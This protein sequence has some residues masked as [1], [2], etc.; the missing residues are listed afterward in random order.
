M[1]LREFL[2]EA[3][4]EG[5]ALTRALDVLAA[6]DISTV[7]LLN[8]AWPEVSSLLRAGPRVLIADALEDKQE[9]PALK[10]P[11]LRKAASTRFTVAAEDGS[12]SVAAA[13][14]DALDVGQWRRGRRASLSRAA[15]RATV[16]ANVGGEDVSEP[17]WRNSGSNVGGED[18][19]EPSCS[20]SLDVQLDQF[21]DEQSHSQSHWSVGTSTM[22]ATPIEGKAMRAA[23]GGSGGASSGSAASGDEIVPQHR[24][25][26]ASH[27]QVE[28][29]EWRAFGYAKHT[30]PARALLAW[31]SSSATRTGSANRWPERDESTAGEPSVLD[32]LPVIAARDMRK[33]DL[34]VA[35]RLSASTATSASPSSASASASH[36]RL[37]SL[38]KAHPFLAVRNSAVLLAVAEL[39]ISTVILH[40]RAFVFSTAAPAPSHGASSSISSISSTATSTTTST[41]TTADASASSLQM[42]LR[43]EAARQSRYAEGAGEGAGGSGVESTFGFQAFDAILSEVGT[44]LRARADE[45]VAISEHL[46]ARSERSLAL[47]SDLATQRQREE[48]RRLDVKLQRA[49]MYAEAVEEVLKQALETDVAYIAASLSADGSDAG[50]PEVEALLESHLHDLGTITALLDMAEVQ[51]EHANSALVNRENETRNRLLRFEVLTSATATGLGMGALISG[52][53]GMNV[54]PEMS[55]FNADS[56]PPWW[57]GRTFFGV[58][59]LII[60]GALFTILAFVGMLYRDV[61]Y[62]R[63][64]ALCKPRKRRAQQPSVLANTTTK[65]YVALSAMMG[66]ERAHGLQSCSPNAVRSRSPAAARARSVTWTNLGPTSHATSCAADGA[67]DGPRPAPGKPPT[68]SRNIRVETPQCVQP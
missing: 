19:S 52:I 12:A 63:L 15:R 56:D 10:R 5:D 24:A 54:S 4:L 6:E 31:L 38:T 33:L 27:R 28:L 57:P 2:L 60:L 30:L 51:V 22:E 23:A 25:S 13:M 1:A 42:V 41:A 65:D 36:A 67:H 7:D 8:K 11:S 66:V 45:L 37:S 46:L 47:I 49:T 59:L 68:R 62:A 50:T 18:V 21:E 64:R 20:P 32:E 44:K 9:V 16:R 53:F 61:L 55:I 58:L 29:I 39:H 34:H 26:E 14:M 48:L 43:L 17:S 35:R 40:G 3:G